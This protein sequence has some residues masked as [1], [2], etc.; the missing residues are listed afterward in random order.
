MWMRPK[1]LGD[2]TGN[3]SSLAGNS[4]C[5]P[6]PVRVAAPGATRREVAGLFLATADAPALRFARRGPRGESRSKSSIQLTEI[7]FSSCRAVIYGGARR[8][9]RKNI[10]GHGAAIGRT[11][12]HVSGNGFGWAR[13]AFPLFHQPAREQGA[14]ILF[15]PLVE[16]GPNLLAEIGGVA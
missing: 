14:R 7:R 1:D 6:L 10:I 4:R 9:I 16:K 12:E 3:C 2:E 8:S 13:G 15:E 5:A 11:R